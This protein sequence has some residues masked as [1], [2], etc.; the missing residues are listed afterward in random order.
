[1]KNQIKSVLVLV[2]ICTVTAL[3]LALT[4]SFTAPIIEE[5]QKAQ[6]N[7]ALLVVMPNGS[8]FE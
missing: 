2:C 5:S 4:N 6:A 7:A 8:G 1:M 3:L